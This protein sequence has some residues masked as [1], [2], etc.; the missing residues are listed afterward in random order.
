MK[1]TP[2]P[3]NH[4]RLWRVLLSAL[5]AL[6][7]LFL[8]WIM[9]SQG[10]TPRRLARIALDTTRAMLDSPRVRSYTQGDY[11]NLVF[12]HQSTGANLIR[13]GQFRQQLT[14][15]GLAAAVRP[16]IAKIAGQALEMSFNSRRKVFRLVFR[17]DQQESAPTE[18]FLPNLH[19]PAGVRVE[20]SDGR[21]E[22]DAE[23]QVLIYAHTQAQEVH[24]VTLRSRTT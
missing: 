23:L 7:A 18:I 9:L 6:I 1:N 10:L 5:L 3:V 4:R 17:H 13:E 19:Y 15:A 11:T 24:A 12:L 14:G 8:A 20:L 21:W 22:L 16:Y 2:D